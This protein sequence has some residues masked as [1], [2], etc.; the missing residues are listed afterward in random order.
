VSGPPGERIFF[1]HVMKTGG[2]TFRRHIEVNLGAEHV[3]PNA[4]LDADLLIANLSIPYVLELPPE[5]VRVI[6]AYTGHFPFIIAEQL[7]QPLVTLTVL[8]DPVERTISYLKHCRRYQEQHRGLPL[9][10][11]YEDERYFATLMD[12]HQAKIFSFTPEDGADSIWTVAT[13]D[14]ARLARARA[15]LE[16]VDV[17]GLHEHYDDFV[18]EASERFGW[19]PAAPPSWH[20]S[21][22]EEIADS[23]RRRITD[24]MAADLEFYEF[25][26]ELHRDR[27][28]RAAPR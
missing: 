24:D 28:R 22:P 9:E 6:K 16:Q 13:V 20:V 14:Q 26:R 10:Q 8:R 7:P 25:A 19:P 1:I 17:V 12:N 23:F 5:R 11:I 4:E 15:N 18:R 21:E 3:F 27:H 2:A